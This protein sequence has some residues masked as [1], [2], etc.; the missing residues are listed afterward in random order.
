MLKEGL[1][2]P[3]FA[4][5]DKDGNRIKVGII[6]CQQTEDMCPGTTDFKVASE[7]TP[8][9]KE[10]RSNCICFMYFKRKSNRNDML[11]FY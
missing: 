4:L 6:R 1:L 8:G 10:S 3:N 7:G 2:A 5:P 9:F 11:Y